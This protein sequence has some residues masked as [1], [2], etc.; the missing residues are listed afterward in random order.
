M[1]GYNLQNLLRTFLNDEISLTGGKKTSVRKH[2]EDSLFGD[3]SCIPF[4]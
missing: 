4:K 3:G 2:I 1:A